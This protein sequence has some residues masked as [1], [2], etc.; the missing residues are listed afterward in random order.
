MDAPSSSEDGTTRL[1]YMSFY[2]DDGGLKLCGCPCTCCLVGDHP[3]D[4]E[5]VVVKLDWTGVSRRLL[6]TAVLFHMVLFCNVM[7]HVSREFYD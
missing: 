5:V 6:Y 1:F 4:L 2:L 3:Y 7:K